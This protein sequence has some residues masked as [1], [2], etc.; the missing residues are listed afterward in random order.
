MVLEY[1]CPGK[2]DFAKQLDLSGKIDNYV[3]FDSFDI[4]IS[5]YKIVNV[6]WKYYKRSPMG[7]YYFFVTLKM[8]PNPTI[9]TNLTLN[10][11]K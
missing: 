9:Q 1:L 11:G 5:Y 4:Y 7:I 10:L 8:H 3:E 2:Q 6:I